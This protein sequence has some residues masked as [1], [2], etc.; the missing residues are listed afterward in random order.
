[1]QSPWRIKLLG[2]LTLQRGQEPP[3]R[4]DTKQTAALMAYL[5][6]HHNR[7]HSRELLA[8][9]L[10]PDEE[11]EAT[12]SRLRTAIWALRRI[13]ESSTVPTGSVLISER[14]DLSLDTHSIL[15][16]VDDFEQAVRAAN[17]ESEATKRAERLCLAADLYSGD[18]LPGCYEEWIAPE[19][20]RLAEIYRQTLNE[21][22]LALSHTGDLARSIEFARRA[23]NVDPLQEDAHAALISLYVRSGR[24]ADARRQYQELERV[25]RTEMGLEPSGAIRELLEP[26]R[27]PA[28][29]EISLNTQPV[30]QR[31]P[32]VSVLNLESEG[33]A[34]PLNSPFYIDRKVDVLFAEAVVRQDS[35]V[36]VKGARQMGK[37]SLLARGL[38]NAREAG[39]RV[40]LTDF[41]QFT[42]DQLQSADSLFLALARDIVD[43]LDL[44]LNID[45]HWHPGWGWNVNF[46]RVLRREILY[47]DCEPIVWG[48]DEVDRLFGRPY[49]MDVFGL[50]RSWHNARS[51]DPAGPW[52]SLTMAIAYATEAHL[53]ITD[54]NQSPFNVGTRLSLSDFTAD[55]VAEL[56][57]RYSEPMRDK[58]E[59]SRFMALVGGQPYL[60]RQG[61]HFLRESG[62]R[63]MEFELVSDRE[64][65]PFGDHLRRMR[66]SLVQD[67]PLTA[68]V[69]SVLGGQPCPTS[70]SFFRL[71]SA[72]LLAGSSAATA[73]LRCG[74]YRRYLERNLL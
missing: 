72:G 31:K 65:G 51:L 2:E 47:R 52:A 46:G 44:D 12:R 60:V 41:Q 8:E 28:I 34:V 43:Q 53:F 54:L 58:Y 24:R 48:L 35:I 6:F 1:M 45:D 62:V 61:L 33:G 63:I 27:N 37:T 69:V 14:S 15:T 73:S 39:K 18:L 5:A 7:R 30:S 10:W 36:L 71:Q 11:N 55:E 17:Q 38:Q 42:T 70:E 4:F 29:D 9:Q 3:V 59:L 67:T 19:R 20:E 74:L 26:P 56:N 32:V 64:D 66:K 16:D 49:S 57:R 21:T 25:L 13:L 40:V 23:V 50:F 22:A 68:A